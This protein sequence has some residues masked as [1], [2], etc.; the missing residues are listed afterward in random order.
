MKITLVVKPDIKLKSEFTTAIKLA[1]THL[2]VTKLV[3]D[4]CI[5]TTLSC[6]RKLT[7][8][9]RGIFDSSSL[10][11]LQLNN[12][13]REYLHKSIRGGDGRYT[14]DE[15]VKYLKANVKNTNKLQGVNFFDYIQID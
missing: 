15:F 7:A 10:C 1:A 2:D 14:L 5:V 3:F 12:Y 13:G 9:F 6:I 11:E 4:D 8:D